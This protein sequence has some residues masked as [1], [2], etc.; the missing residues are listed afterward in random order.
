MGMDCTRPALWQDAFHL[1]S[2]AVAN[3]W[4][5]QR[6]KQRFKT[7]S[8]KAKVRHHAL[9][10]S[11]PSISNSFR[12]S[13]IFMTQICRKLFALA[14]H[15]RQ[16]RA[17][18]VGRTDWFYLPSVRLRGHLHILGKVRDLLSVLSLQFGLALRSRPPKWNASWRI[19]Y[20]RVQSRDGAAMSREGRRRIMG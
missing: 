7:A 1:L 11:L 9:L 3:I 8:W 10:S 14:L 15:W 16:E 20:M 6:F 5:C 13:C 4:C 2:A 17:K 19:R 12:S 18:A